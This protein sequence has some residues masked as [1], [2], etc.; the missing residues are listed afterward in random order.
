MVRQGRDDDAREFFLK[1]L[2]VNQDYGPIYQVLGD[3]FSR[4]GLNSEA[5]KM[6]EKAVQLLPPDHANLKIARERLAALKGGVER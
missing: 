6:Y 1:A 4:K 5:A 2:E 3:L